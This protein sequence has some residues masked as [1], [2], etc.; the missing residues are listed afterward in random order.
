MS[1]YVRSDHWAALIAPMYKL[2]VGF[3]VLA[4]I[5][6]PWEMSSAQ[7]SAVALV[8]QSLSVCLINH[9]C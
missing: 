4:L 9:S 3:V 7:L 1:C 5:S 6:W 2:I 8:N